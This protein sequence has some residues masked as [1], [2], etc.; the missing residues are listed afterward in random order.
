MNREPDLTT[1]QG[2]NEICFEVFTGVMAMVTHEIR[3]AL[4]IINESAGYLDDL[5]LMSG[6]DECVPGA[7]VQGMVA[8]ISDQVA[9]ANKLMKEM[10]AF[11]HSGDTPN[12][13]I[14]LHDTLAMMLA[15]THRKAAACKIMIALKDS[16]GPLLTT[17]PLVLE[18]LIYLFLDGMY[19]ALPPDSR[20]TVETQEVDSTAFLHFRLESEG[21]LPSKICSESR[22]KLL[23]EDIR[24]TC[25]C[26][27]KKIVIRL[28]SC[29]VLHC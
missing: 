29:T 15:L 24:A 23:S 28:D 22:V 18:A 11:A 25:N 20:L 4:A 9:R 27:E 3:N 6:D 13:R 7:R 10:N 8:N 5:A 2:V 26:E 12:A 16:G 19:E 21:G 17:R 1:N 14:D